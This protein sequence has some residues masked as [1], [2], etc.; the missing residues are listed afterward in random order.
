MLRL[1]LGCLHERRRPIVSGINVYSPPTLRVMAD[2]CASQ[3][4]FWLSAAAQI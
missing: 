3:L 1:S 4:H 2:T